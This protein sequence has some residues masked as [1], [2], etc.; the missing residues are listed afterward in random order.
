MQHIRDG[1][2]IP[3][4]KTGVDDP[5]QDRQGVHRASGEVL[6]RHDDLDVFNLENPRET[7]SS[8]RTR[9]DHSVHLTTGHTLISTP[10]GERVMMSITA[11]TVQHRPSPRGTL[12]HDLLFGRCSRMGQLQRHGLAVVSGCQENLA[13][14]IAEFGLTPDYVHDP[15]NIFMKSGLDEWGRPFYE[16]PDAQAGDYVELRAEIDCLVAISACPGRSSG[17][18]PHRLGIQIFEPDGEGT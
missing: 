10:P 17:P 9:C 13:E 12:S 14:A 11:D 2:G 7:F 16:D 1:R 6:A 4:A 18:V 8:S 5:T 15:F 3:D